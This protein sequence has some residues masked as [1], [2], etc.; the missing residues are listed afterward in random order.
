MDEIEPGRERTSPRGVWTLG[1]P[2]VIQGRETVS[3]LAPWMTQRGTRGEPWVIQGSETVSH[4]ALGMTHHSK[5]A[6]A[7][8]YFFG[9]KNFDYP[10]AL[11]RREGAWGRL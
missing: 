11:V 3:H 4:L 7:N 1:E 10:F 6:L 2:W 8:A 5:F 9:N